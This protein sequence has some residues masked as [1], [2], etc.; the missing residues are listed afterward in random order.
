MRRR[1]FLI[2]VLFF[3]GCQ[4]VKK[5]ASPFSVTGFWSSQEVKQ[6]KVL[7]RGTG[8]LP[9]SIP[10]KGKLAV[11]E[12]YT[13]GPGDKLQIVIQNQKEISGEYI[14]NE[15]GFIR[16][17]L[18]GLFQV[19]GNTLTQI[20]SQLEETL[21]KFL[22]Q[23]VVMIDLS[24]SLNKQVFVYG[25]LG[26]FGPLKQMEVFN[27][28]KPTKI[29]SLLASLGGPKP[30]ADI[31][32]ISISHA[33]G[34]RN[35]INLNRIL[36]QGD[37]SQNIFLKPGD[38]VYIP[39]SATG[40]NKVLVLGAVQQPGLFSFESE[41]TALQAIA[42][43]KSFSKNA[44]V[45]DSFV[46]RTT[47]K[48]PYLLRVNFKRLLMQGEAQRDIPLQK[49][50]IVFVPDNMIT[51]Y[52]RYLERIRPT[53]DIL[54]DI[55]GLVIDADTISVAFDRGFGEASETG[56]TELT[57]AEITRT[58]ERAAESAATPP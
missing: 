13:I 22:R 33:D 5:E 21:K 2:M 4:G 40:E 49:G 30:D 46:I 18:I 50:D 1:I 19:Q 24:E 42:L 45:E 8:V 36:L 54:K 57:T 48:N 15:V 29:L 39:S 56:T 12:M 17:P 41:I 38:I 35:L 28:N 7:D 20:Q 14:V 10:L 25:A 16:F 53:L 44:R 31:R 3:A 6:K 37:Q 34:S 32:N 52:N 43:A 9:T 27:L 23:P 55:A 47:V 58:A 11:A 51:N 26:D